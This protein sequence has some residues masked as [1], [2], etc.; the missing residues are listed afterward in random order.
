MGL[1]IAHGQ[2]P[3]TRWASRGLSPPGRLTVR[4]ATRGG[5]A[6]PVRVRVRGRLDSGR[7]RVET[8]APE[9]FHWMWEVGAAVTELVFASVD[10]VEL[11]GLAE[12]THWEVSGFGLAAR[13][14]FAPL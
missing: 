7:V 10:S 6:H 11:A 2:G 4:V 14:G 1:T 12:D 3:A 9:R 13:T 8:I 5:E